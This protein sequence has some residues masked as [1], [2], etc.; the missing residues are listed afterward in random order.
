MVLN[1]V[2]QENRSD[3]KYRETHKMSVK[4][5]NKFNFKET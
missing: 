1:R 5:R 4:L 2:V 3:V